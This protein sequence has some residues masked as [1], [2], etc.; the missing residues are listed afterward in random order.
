[1]PREKSKVL[2]LM[3]GSEAGRSLE[4]L[5]VGEWAGPAGGAALIPAG[6]PGRIQ[7]ENEGGLEAPPMLAQRA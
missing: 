3:G 1:M 4:N 2:L 5:V 6:K 7:M